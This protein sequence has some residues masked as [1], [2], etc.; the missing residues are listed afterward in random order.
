MSHSTD[1]ES[2]AHSEG[3]REIRSWA[4]RSPASARPGFRKKHR[5]GRPRLSPRL[6]G[7]A[8][9]ALLLVL[10]SLA[11]YQYFFQS[12]QDTPQQATIPAL[13]TVPELEEIPK[14]DE[15]PP[16]SPPAAPAEKE[17]IPD[18]LQARTEPLRLQAAPPT[19]PAPRERP[20]QAA[21]LVRREPVLNEPKASSAI[22]VGRDVFESEPA[23]LLS[24]PTAE[25]PEAA[26]GTGTSAEVIVGFTIDETGTVRN[27]VIER[28]QIQGDAPKAPFEQ[29]ALT[30][31]RSARFEPARERGVPT[32]SWSNLTFSFETVSASAGI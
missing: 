21:A 12:R 2:T 16:A 9:L 6:A 10:F 27:P 11:S 14:T 19:P 25:Y 24:V 23:V 31:V 18:R 28:I 32:R 3:L 20:L 13:A 15:A 7:S 22:V 8:L 26:R 29:A 5:T 4:S 17:V 30:A 1:I